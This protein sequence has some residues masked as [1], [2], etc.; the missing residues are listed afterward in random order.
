MSIRKHLRPGKKWLTIKS[1]EMTWDE[2]VK[3]IKKKKLVCP[4]EQQ[5][6]IEEADLLNAAYGMLT[7]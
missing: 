2:V 3:E 4:T 6:N 5:K 1:S 7:T